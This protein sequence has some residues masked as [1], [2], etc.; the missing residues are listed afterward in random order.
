[1]SVHMSARMSK[2]VP[3]HVETQV[4]MWL[5]IA[6]ATQRH[7]LIAYAAQRHTRIT[8]LQPRGKGPT[9]HRPQVSQIQPRFIGLYS[10]A[11]QVERGFINAPGRDS[12]T[13]TMHMCARMAVCVS[14]HLRRAVGACSNPRM[15]CSC[16]QTC[17]HAPM[18]Q[19]AYMHVCVVHVDMCDE[20]LA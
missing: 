6:Y 4:H 17:L 20:L 10:H 12:P 13:T 18:F 15:I 7:T 1:M 16:V 3:I 11:I 19:C 2:H 8:Q 14:L 9:N 5:L